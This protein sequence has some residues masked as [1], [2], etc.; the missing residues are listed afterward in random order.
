MNNP[1]EQDDL[2]QLLG[3]AKTPQVSP[4][5][6]RNVLREIRPANQEK[7]GVFPWLLHQLRPLALGCIAAVLLVLNLGQFFRPHDTLTPPP[8]Q[9]VAVQKSQ[10]VPTK[11][12]VEVIKNLD[13][14]LAYE[15]H[16]IWLD[17]STQ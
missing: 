1:E 3:K 10:P 5:F 4:F 15:E 12:D 11:S 16:S 8:N 9:S 13:E 14:L 2:W 17:D 7:S 6:A